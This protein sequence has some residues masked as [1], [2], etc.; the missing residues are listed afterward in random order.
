MTSC[1]PGNPSK[2]DCPLGLL[3]LLPLQWVPATSMAL[4][5]PAGGL[6]TLQYAGQQNPADVAAAAAAAAQMPIPGMVPIMPIMM[7]P[8]LPPA[9]L[10]PGGAAASGGT[11]ADA[12]QQAAAAAAA[13]AAAVSLMAPGAPVMV[14]QPAG[15]G[16]TQALQQVGGRIGGV[17]H[18]LFLD[19]QAAHVRIQVQAS[20]HFW[21]PSSLGQLPVYPAQPTCLLSV[22]LGP[23]LLPQRKQ[24]R[25]M[26]DKVLDHG[27]R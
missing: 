1:L 12:A 6:P 7:P 8:I 3:L 26:P 16:D 27:S 10:A 23:C 15:P 13:A 18:L 20:R 11:P 22:S 5:V 4:F 14:P 25:T 2:T 19:R 24:W 17:V 9:G 21:E